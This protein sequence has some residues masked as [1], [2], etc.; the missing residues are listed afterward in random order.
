[1]VTDERY[2]HTDPDVRLSLTCICRF[3]LAV[4][5]YIAV[6]SGI[7]LALG[8]RSATDVFPNYVFWIG[9][10]YLLLVRRHALFLVDVIFGQF[11]YHIFILTHKHPNTENSEIGISV[12]TCCDISV[13]YHLP[14]VV[15]T[16]L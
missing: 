1:M 2:V 14:S 12:N 8:K 13:S 15:Y 7:N 4:V 3:L 6:G 5:T 9:F 10:P 11:T 16:Y